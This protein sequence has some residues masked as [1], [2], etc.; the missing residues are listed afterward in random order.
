MRTL[1]TLAFISLLSSCVLA[2]NVA[3]RV[4]DEANLPLAGASIFLDGTALAVT[5]QDGYFD[6][7]DLPAGE[8]LLR[9]TYIGFVPAERAVEVQS[10]QTTSL[11]V[12][13]T[14]GVQLTE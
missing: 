13:L 10:G 12:Q 1:Y 3:G 2:Q 14:P 7:L 4:V 6:L 5:D 9:F 8:H 11:D